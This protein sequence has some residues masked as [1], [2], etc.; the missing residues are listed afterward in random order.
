MSR[1]R[2]TSRQNPLLVHVKK[3]LRSRAYR[4]KCGE[5]AA[6]GTKLLEE[7]V[8][9]DRDLLTVIVQE[10]VSVCELPPAVRVAEISESLMRDLSQMEAPQGAIFVCRLPEQK[11]VS[12][13][14]GSL[15]L[16]G[17]QDPGN[18]GTILRTAD[19]L[20]IPVI[21]T[22]GCADVY[23]PKTVRASMGAVFRTAPVQLA[24]Q[25]VIRQ[26]AASG[27][28]LL[29]AAMGEDA[30]DIRTVPLSEV[31]TVVGSEGRGVCAELLAAADGSV[32]IPMSERCESLNAAIAA[33]IIM[34]Q[35]KR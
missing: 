28:P 16:D 30:K 4:E 11:P 2:I 29:A 23:S 17:I 27:I 21:L 15:L 25:E 31:L 12:I 3:L 13:R 1:E 32:V 33:A 26:C 7:A 10:G 19:A 18:L 24:K 22:E 9:W 14:R 35:M 20:Q 6:D 5:F 34:W 8:R